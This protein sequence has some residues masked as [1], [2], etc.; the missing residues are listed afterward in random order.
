MSG[1]LNL[2]F[3]PRRFQNRHRVA[4]R[5]VRRL[6]EL[7]AGAN[8]GLTELIRGSAGHVNRPRDMKAAPVPLPGFT[9][10]TRWTLP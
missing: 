4:R 2:W 10:P 3:K 6:P 8:E 7:S 1:V 9:A 5:R